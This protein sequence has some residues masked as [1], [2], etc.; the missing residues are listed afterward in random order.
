MI[1]FHFTNI[2]GLLTTFEAYSSR[3]SWRVFDI[4]APSLKLYPFSTVDDLPFSVKV[5]K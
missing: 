1:D 3:R 2:Y 4:A 5:D